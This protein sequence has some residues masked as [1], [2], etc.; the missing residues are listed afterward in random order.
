VLCAGGSSQLLVLNGVNRSDSRRVDRVVG[1]LGTTSLL[2]AA[3]HHCAMFTLAGHL[4]LQA[5]RRE[6]FHVAMIGLRC[7]KAVRRQD[8]QRAELGN[9][10]E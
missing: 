9:D 8:T 5:V 10:Y 7:S 6:T 1:G 3:L 4:V 2:L